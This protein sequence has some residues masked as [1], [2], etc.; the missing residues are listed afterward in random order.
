MIKSVTQCYFSV[1]HG[2]SIKKRVDLKDKN[3]MTDILIRLFR[4]LITFPNRGKT[5]SCHLPV[6]GP[7]N[8]SK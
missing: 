4:N 7:L 3:V 8:V 1:K 2:N 5:K 6:Y